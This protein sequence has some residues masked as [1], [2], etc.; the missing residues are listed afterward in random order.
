QWYQNGTVPV[1]SGIATGT[2]S[3][4]LEGP[5]PKVTVYT[6]SNAVAN[7]VLNNVS[8]GN[9]GNYTVVFS[10][11]WGSVTSTPTSLTVTSAPVIIAEP[12]PQSVLVGQNTSFSVTAS[13]T[14]PLSYQWQRVGLGNLSNG[15]VYSGVNTSTLTLTGV[16]MGNAG[17]YLVVITN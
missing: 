15:G 6:Y 4:V 7:L 14:D 9:T 12:S 10:N 2:V 13:G 16:G 5:V 1:S 11:Y 17:N 3:T 8:N